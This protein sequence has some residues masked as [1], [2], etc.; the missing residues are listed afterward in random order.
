MTDADVDSYHIEHALTTL[1]CRLG[2]IIEFRLHLHLI[3]TIYRITAEKEHCGDDDA[4]QILKIH[5]I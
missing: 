4:R 2:L 1:F 3:S 5:E